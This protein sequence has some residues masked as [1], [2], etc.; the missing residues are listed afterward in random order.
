MPVF[1][2]WNTVYASSQIYNPNQ[3]SEVREEGGVATKQTKIGVVRQLDLER[4]G[5]HAV[6]V[7]DLNEAVLGRSTKCGR[8]R[9]CA[10]LHGA[11]GEQTDQPT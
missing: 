1:F 4:V 6:Q 5:D 2:T 3:N 7:H 11:P 9:Q 10:I 8:S